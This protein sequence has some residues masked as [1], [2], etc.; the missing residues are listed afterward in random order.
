MWVSSL[1]REASLVPAPAMA[2]L[3]IA[4]ISFSPIG[5]GVSDPSDLAVGAGVAVCCATGPVGPQAQASS[6]G[7]I[8]TVASLGGREIIK[9]ASA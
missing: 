2:V 3:I 4:S 7:T 8:K 5:T 6:N 1:L 9:I